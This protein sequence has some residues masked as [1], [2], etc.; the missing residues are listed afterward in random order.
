MT[1]S[2]QEPGY[3]PVDVDSGGVGL[4]AAML[5]LGLIFCSIVAA[6]YYQALS[7]HTRRREG[8]I[9]PSVATTQRKFPPP[10]LQVRPPEDLAALRAREEAMLTR[11]GW[12]DRE[13]GEVRIPI[14]RAMELL[15]KRG[16]PVGEGSGPEKS[17]GPTWEEIMQ[18]RVLQGAGGNAERSLP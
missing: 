13:K 6:L 12:V 3:E 2:G 10:R 4:V 17:A 5:V 1:P 18:Q 9:L 7:V 16:L 14:D 11:Y 15:V 8:P